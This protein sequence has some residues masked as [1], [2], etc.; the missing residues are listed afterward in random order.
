[1][2]IDV[3]MIVRIVV[4]GLFLLVTAIIFYSWGLWDGERRR[5]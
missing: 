3:Q 1:M 5:D 4:A 2:C